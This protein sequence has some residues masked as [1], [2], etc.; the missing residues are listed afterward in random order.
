MT[1]H[2]SVF[3]KKGLRSICSQVFRKLQAISK[4]NKKK[5]LRPQIRIFSTKFVRK[6]I[7]F[8]KF[9]VVLQDET[10]LLMTL[11]HFQPVKK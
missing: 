5:G 3:P 7:F 4:K 10:T 1:Q 2:G 9:S 6:K 8:C 11:A